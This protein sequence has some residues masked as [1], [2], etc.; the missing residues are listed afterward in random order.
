MGQSVSVH[1]K[2]VDDTELV[3][4]TGTPEGHAAIWRDLDRLEKWA[5][6]NLMKFNKGSCK[7]GK[8]PCI[9]TCWGLTSWKAALQKRTWRS[10]WT[11]S[12]P[13]ASNVLLQQCRQMVSWA[14][15]GGVL[16]AGQALYT[17][18][19]RPY[20][21][22]CV[23]FWAPWYKWDT[24]ILEKAQWR[25]ACMIKELEHLLYEERLKELRLFS[26]EKAQG[27]SHQCL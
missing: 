12:W 25:P 8:T 21:E 7:G 16:P 1:S 24:G 4:V 15:L 3:D 2:L 20:L 22:C 26:L 10:W 9:S 6:R 14:A 18:L 5:D 27:G 17:A 19:V 13:W 23:Q 11:P